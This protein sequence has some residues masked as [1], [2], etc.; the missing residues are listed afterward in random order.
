MDRVDRCPN[1]Y[2]G[3]SAPGFLLN[4]LNTGHGSVECLP[5]AGVKG[6]VRVFGQATANAVQGSSFVALS[7]DFQN[8]WYLAPPDPSAEQNFSLNV[9]G[10][11]TQRGTISVQPTSTTALEIQSDALEVA[12]TLYD[13]PLDYAES[14]CALAVLQDGNSVAG[15]LCGR[16]A[17]FIF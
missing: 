8:C 17:G 2:E 4:R 3:F 14:D 12:G 9:K 15:T 13:P 10:L 16:N 5:V 7:Y 11:L 6:S 1:S